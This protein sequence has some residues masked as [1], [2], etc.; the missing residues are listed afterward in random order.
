VR[1]LVKMTQLRLL[2]YAERGALAQVLR[3]PTVLS[4]REG[5]PSD[6]TSGVR[7]A[8]GLVLTERE[9][10]GSQVRVQGLAGNVA[11]EGWAPADALGV[12]YEEHE[13]EV[14]F[15]DGLVREGTAVLAGP[16]GPTLATL[17]TVPTGARPFSLAVEPEDG[18]P[19]GWQRIRL[20][21]RE[22]E[23]WGLVASTDYRPKPPGSRRLGRSHRHRPP[24]GALS[25]SLR[26]TLPIGAALYAPED[27][28]CIGRVIQPLTVHYDFGPPGPG[29]LRTV[30]LFA[31]ELGLT[32]AL[33]NAADVVP[34]AAP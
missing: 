23:V 31:E 5:L 14:A 21:T 28:S 17:G 22:V 26:G 29:G 34:D 2:L 32:V 13:L 27:H 25:D 15:G 16:G 33:A 9:R 8:P 24:G 4:A 30:Y 6:A 7:V 18:A 3:V 12:V 11:F 20:R 19:K 10:R 1:L